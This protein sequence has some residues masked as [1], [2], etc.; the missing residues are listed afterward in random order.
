LRCRR[1]DRDF[2]DLKATNPADITPI[3]S[4]F[5]PLMELAGIVGD[6]PLSK[7][8]AVLDEARHPKA[9]DDLA[10]YA[11]DGFAVEYVYEGDPG[12]DFYGPTP[13]TKD[14]AKRNWNFRKAVHYLEEE[15]IHL[16]SLLKIPVAAQG[17]VEDIKLAYGTAIGNKIDEESL[18]WPDLA[19]SYRSFAG[20]LQKVIINDR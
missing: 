18:D 8:D 17:I 2:D 10:Q 11:L 13:E 15:G 20:L 9:I 5:Q 16:A 12:V 3:H 4:S 19:V 7:H 1:G 14:I 6:W